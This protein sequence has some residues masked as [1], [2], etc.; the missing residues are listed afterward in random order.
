M[1]QLRDISKDWREPETKPSC[2]VKLVKMGDTL[3]KLSA[4][5]FKDFI[6]LSVLI[7]L[8]RPYYPLF[9]LFPLPINRFIG[10]HIQVNYSL[11]KL[12]IKKLFFLQVDAKIE[13][14]MNT[15]ECPVCL[16]TADHPPIYQCPGLNAINNSLTGRHL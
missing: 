5:A 7:Y 1:G 15:L 14:L 6:N 11:C 9:S 4:R 12:I 8:N 3:G 10:A 16:D 13:D 2:L